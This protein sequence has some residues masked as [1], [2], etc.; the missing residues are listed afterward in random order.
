MIPFLPEPSITPGPLAGAAAMPLA[1]PGAGLD[2]AG[3]LSAALPAARLPGGTVL[4]DDGAVLPYMAAPT[5]TDAGT[6][7]VAQTPDTLALPT[8]PEGSPPTVAGPVVPE[9]AEQSKAA[10]Q[11]SPDVDAEEAETGQPA[12]AANEPETPVPNPATVAVISAN[13]AVSTPPPPRTIPRA[14]LHAAASPAQAENSP[15]PTRVSLPATPDDVA[16]APAPAAMPAAVPKLAEVEAE[17]PSPAAP[18]AATAPSAAQ[19]ANSAT[20][21]L[22]APSASTPVAASAEPRAPAPQQESTIAQVGELREALRAARPEMTMR[23]AEFGLVS[24]RVDATGAEGWRAVLA[25]RDPGF[26]PAIQAALT[27]RTIAAAADTSGTNA[28]TNGSGQN[29]QSDQRYGSSPNGGEG[30]SQPYLAQSS[31]RHEGSQPHPQQRQPRTTDTVATR[32]GDADAQHGDP[33][34]RGVFA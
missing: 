29:G 6:V 32:A 2:F 28:G 12:P 10:P 26:V 21:A 34:Q 33:R 19:T 4:P 13:L 20:A 9:A 27:D 11:G 23:H 1:Q 24:V 15:L 16:P 30:S 8:I 17:L 25:S 22:T 7:S 5:I 14:L 18:S 3:L 31:G